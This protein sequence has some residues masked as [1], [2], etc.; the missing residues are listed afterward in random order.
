MSNLEV[1]KESIV[2]GLDAEQLINEPIRSSQDII[3]EYGEYTEMPSLKSCI[4]TTANF[5]LEEE[6]Y[7]KDNL[8]LIYNKLWDMEG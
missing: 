8:Q 3:N 2:L 1:E 5:N 7:S 6:T 4:D